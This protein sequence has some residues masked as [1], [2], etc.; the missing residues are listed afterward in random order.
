[1]NSFAIEQIVG[2]SAWTERVHKRIVQVAKYRYSVLISG[3]SGTG[4]ELVARAIH[5]HGSRK[6]KP[7]IPVN[8]AA[9]PGGLFNSQLFGHVKGAF[10]GAEYAALGC[11]RAADGGT[12]FLDEVG[13]LDLGS[14]AKLLR[15]LQERQVVPVGSHDGV[16]VD[17]RVIAATNRKLSDEVRAGKFRLDL[18]YRL[19]VLSVQ[20]LGLKD[21]VEDVEILTNHFLAKTA[22]EVGGA[23]KRLSASAL[24][25][26][27]SYTWPGNVRELQNLIEQAVVFSEG[28]VIGPE[29]FASI[30]EA[31]YDLCG[32]PVD[33]AGPMPPVRA[34][35]PMPVSDLDSIPAAEPPLTGKWQTLEEME[36]DH[37]RRAL[38]ETFFNYSAAARLLAIDRKQLSRKVK[39]HGLVKPKGCPESK[40]KKQPPT[41]MDRSL[42]N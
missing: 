3:P 28:S 22:V 35:A 25:M 41:D 20:T 2:R 6:D 26:L 9:I 14:Q 8:C 12:I 21:R 16:P 13:E 18:Y 36:A 29:A 39:R 23:I 4:K 40:Q 11:F 19:N 15:V 38:D 24:A 42:T 1:M 30:M 37:I 10:T 31:N 27:Q 5:S 34:R 33:T 32:L 7:F 17:V